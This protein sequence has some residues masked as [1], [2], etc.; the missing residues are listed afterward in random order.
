MTETK[1]QV[2]IVDDELDAL[3]NHLAELESA[4]AIRVPAVMRSRSQ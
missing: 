1:R 3:Q 4:G 2:L